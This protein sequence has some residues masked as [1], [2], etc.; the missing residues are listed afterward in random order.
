L[1]AIESGSLSVGSL[2]FVL[3]TTIAN[4]SQTYPQLF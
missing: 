1:A 2:L 3:A 4:L